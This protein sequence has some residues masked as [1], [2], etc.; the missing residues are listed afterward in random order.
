MII[1]LIWQKHFG[2]KNLCCENVMI[3][4]STYLEKYLSKNSFCC[5]QISTKFLDVRFL[6]VFT[7]LKFAAESS[8]FKFQVFTRC[9]LSSLSNGIQNFSQKRLSKI[10]MKMQWTTQIS[11]RRR[12]YFPVAEYL[13]WQFPLQISMIWGRF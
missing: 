5:I 11:T 3:S 1:T 2:N 6:E 8:L 13:I 12:R 9:V 10:R 4:L 7:G